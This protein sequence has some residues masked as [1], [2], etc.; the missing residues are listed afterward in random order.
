MG[1]SDELPGFKKKRRVLFS[2][3]SAPQK[4]CEVG[5]QFMAAERYDDALECFQRAEAEDLVRQVA[6]IAME[7]GNTPLYMR[8]KKVLQE[9]ITDA[10]WTQIADRAEAAGLDSCAYLAH[11]QPGHEEEAARLRRRLPIQGAEDDDAVARD[12]ALSPG[13]EQNGQ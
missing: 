6:G 12:K 5:E 1:K 13:P 2:P 7:E 4:L 9:E 8:A 10:E 3:K 11:S